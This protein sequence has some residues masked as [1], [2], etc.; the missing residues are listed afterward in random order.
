[1]T[2]VTYAGLPSSDPLGPP[3]VPSAGG[4]IGPV[5]TERNQHGR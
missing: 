2:A 5:P 3:A 4:V 1:M